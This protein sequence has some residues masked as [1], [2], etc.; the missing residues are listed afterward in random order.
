MRK[1]FLMSIL[2][3]LLSANVALSDVAP[4]SPVV[5]DWMMQD[6]RTEPADVA[7]IQASQQ[8]RAERLA[9]LKET[10]PK[11]I[12]V[13][14]FDLG[15]AHYAYTEGQSDAQAERHFVAGSAL[16]I[17]EL[18]A[19]GEYEERTLLSDPSGVIR[20]PD[21]SFDGK[22]IVFAWKKSD[23]LDDYHLYDYDVETGAI[24]QLT[25]GLGYADYE[26]CVLP[27]GDI[28]FNSTR[29]VQ[30]VDCWW[31]EVSNLYICDKDGRFLRRLSF[32]Q[33][34]TNF[35]AILEDARIIYTRWDYND[36][37]QVFPQPLFQMN[38]DGTGQTEFYGNNSWFPTTLMHA[39]G[40][41]NSGGKVVAV[42]SGHHNMYY[43]KLGIVDIS[44]GRQENTGTQLIAPIRETTADRIDAWGQ[45][46]DRFAYPYPLNEREFIVS[47]N[48][49]QTA[50]HTVKTPFGIYW[51]DEEGNR[52]LLAYDSTISSF[53]PVPLVARPEPSVRPSAVNPDV[54][55]GTFTMQDVYFGPGLEG[56]ERGTA[57]TLRVIALEF[58]STGIGSNNNS[59]PGG[60]GDASS[61]I[62]VGNG[63]WDVKVILGDT[64]I[65]EDGSASFR[66]PAKTPL[67]FQVLD[68]NGHSIQ[69][70]RSWSTLQPG[71]V[72]SC[73][74]CHEDK[75]LVSTPTLTLAEAMRRPPATLQPFYGEPRGFSFA[76]EVQPT[77]DAHCVECHQNPAKN[78]P[79][80]LPG[81]QILSEDWTRQGLEQPLFEDLKDWHYTT[82]KP[83]NDWMK[84]EYFE[85]VK[86]LPKSEGGFGA[87]PGKVL[88]TRWNTHDI[89]YWRT[90]ELPEDWTAQP[91]A[92]RYFHDED[93]T[94]YV[95]GQQIFS[96]TGYNT[97]YQSAIIASKETQ[98][99]KPG[100][101]YLAA[102]THQ[103]FGGQGVDFGLWTIK[104]EMRPD[105]PVVEDRLAHLPF[106]L[107]GDLV[108]DSRAKRHWPLSYLNLT[109]SRQISN[110]SYF[111][112][113]TPAVNWVSV[114]SAPPI[115]PPYDAGAATSGIM[116]MLDPNLAEG[117]KTHNDVK[118]SREE[119]DKLAAW[120]DLLV[121]AFGDYEEG[122]AWN[123]VEKR[124]FA[125]Y[126]AKRRD[127][128]AFDI[129]KNQQFA[130]W[131]KE[132]TLP[133]LPQDP[134]VYRNMVTTP[135]TVEATGWQVNFD[136]PINTDQVVIV[137]QTDDP[138]ALSLMECVIEC[139]NGFKQKV[140]LK[141]SEDIRRK[142]FVF[143]I[144]RNVSW[145]KL[146]DFNPPF[147]AVFPNSVATSADVEVYG[148]DH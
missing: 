105:E 108:H 143:P 56:I 82:E 10:F 38:P 80:R 75:N 45:Y 85:Q 69:T 83:Q 68:E 28:I 13:K 146:S 132:G 66:V 122:N 2:A 61:P 24:R 30:I 70:M 104:P 147:P 100:I 18:N 48:P 90:L 140:V 41:P 79:Y 98:A 42:F 93:T 44:K 131:L 22:S 47:Y 145:I 81:P 128:D 86:N 11:I 33:V 125:Y 127:M 36:R 29:C 14:H 92:I 113:Q 96:I 7:Y 107:K 19:D 106:S 27:N 37:G 76:R 16:C 1:F 25:F 118:L 64:P 40:I 139:S 87:M 134:N 103:T 123:E 57:K 135:K 133:P 65:H 59:G 148:I 49:D 39:R 121:P 116:Q 35:P 5:Q 26:P 63:T 111:A 126:E 62:A 136:K 43:G 9:T 4:D 32:D 101:N 102:H 115:L 51:M 124:K 74:G 137:F 60:G 71:E 8:R 99:F 52:E 17:L 72:F 142:V 31:T 117:G 20:D 12:F 138:R 67:Y 53:R 73:L 88:P 50:G 109:N 23:R 112:A 84:P 94:I 95:N 91:L 110:G 58:R 130:A 55:Y 3:A 21:V 6:A 120:L 78:P 97:R 89:W 34:H 15:G 77:L 141:S 114:Q 54:D 144:Q 119:L 129:L 46:G